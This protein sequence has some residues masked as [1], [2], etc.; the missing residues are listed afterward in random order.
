M[1]R[2][3]KNATAIYTGGGLYIFYG[4]LTDGNWFR[5]YDEWE[6]IEICDADTSTEEADYNEFYEEHII[7]TLVNDEYKTFWNDMLLWIIHNAPEGNYSVDELEKRIIEKEEES[8]H[9]LEEDL[10][11]LEILLRSYVV[12]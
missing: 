6:C 9:F 3:I 7:E 2:E 10:K 12:W 4:Q 5:A 1:K 11:T 8:H